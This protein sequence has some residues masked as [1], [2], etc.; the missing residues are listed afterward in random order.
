MMLEMSSAVLLQVGT[1]A[2]SAG[3][4]RGFSGFG[5][6]LVGVPLLSMILAP[7]DFV[8]LIFSMQLVAAVP[9]LRQTL[10]EA[11]G[12]QILPLLA[13]GVPGTWAGLWLLGRLEPVMIGL[14]IAAAVTL[15]AVFLFSGWRLQRRRP[16]RAT[17]R[18]ASGTNTGRCASVR[19]E[20]PATRLP[21]RR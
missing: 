15:V 14:A 9:G 19:I 4:I 3:I 7:P 16:W 5:F 20:F 2:L 17:G 12:R 6:A 18:A 21:S 8:P 13:G 11:D 10:R 1:I